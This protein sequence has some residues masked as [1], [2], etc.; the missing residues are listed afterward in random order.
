MISKIGR[1]NLVVNIWSST[2]SSRVIETETTTGQ[3]PEECWSL[4]EL[5]CG[6]AGRVREELFCCSLWS[7]ACTCNPVPPAWLHAFASQSLR[8]EDV[9][10][11]GYGS[12]QQGRVWHELRS[13]CGEV[14]FHLASVAIWYGT[15]KS[16]LEWKH[17]CCWCPVRCE[18]S[19]LAQLVDRLAEEEWRRPDE[20][21]Y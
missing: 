14:C 16:P 8:E 6:S 10:G 1:E 12:A 3:R 7:S 21:V 5:V 15:G 4:S 11:P 9:S 17:A 18:R 13:G 2:G 20:G 19:H